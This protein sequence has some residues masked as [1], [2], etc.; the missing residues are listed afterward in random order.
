MS[1]DQQIKAISQEITKQIDQ[2]EQD[3]ISRQAEHQPIAPDNA[4]G[5]LTRMDALVQS[6]VLQASIEQTKAKLANLQRA[7]RKIA[8]NDYGFC[9][10][11]D[12]QISWQRLSFLPEVKYC[13]GCADNK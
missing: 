5:R 3:L 12:Q 8:Q 4:I 13:V 7:Q 11:C 9:E 2:C 1:R 10:A 6:E